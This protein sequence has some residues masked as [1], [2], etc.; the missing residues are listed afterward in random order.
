MTRENYWQAIDADTWRDAMTEAVGQ[1]DELGQWARLASMVH[2]DASP[3]RSYHAGV[4]SGQESPRGAAPAPDPF[5][6]VRHQTHSKR[7]NSGRTATR[8]T[9]AGKVYVIGP[10]PFRD[11]IE[12]VRVDGITLT[13]LADAWHAIYGG[14]H[15]CT[16]DDLT[17]T[18]PIY[19]RGKMVVRNGEPVTR[20]VALRACHCSPFPRLAG[21]DLR[22]Y[23]EVTPE[24]RDASYV[25]PT[26]T[27]RTGIAGGLLSDSEHV[28]RTIRGRRA[29]GT[30]YAVTEHGRY[31]DAI[32]DRSV[33]TIDTAS[34]PT[35]VRLS[36][37]PRKSDPTEST[38][39]GVTE[40][41][42]PASDR[43]HLWHGHRLI[44]RASAVRSGSDTRARRNAR[45]RAAAPWTPFVPAVRA[46]I[47][48]TDPF[49]LNGVM[50]TLTLPGATGRFR[51]RLTY[52]DGTTESIQART[53]DRVARA[54]Y[55]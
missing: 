20:T 30:R 40:L 4:K 7:S 37:R 17:E 9:R 27:H 1:Y 6:G 55:R 34:H 38:R 14:E 10:D 12:L 8:V 45:A 39:D 21:T 28:S 50:V 33:P 53:P 35:R 52:C 31:G 15:E 19:R 13:A 22:A 29:D 48:T 18:R 54:I 44:P 23:A 32:T 51:A 43:E 49:T 5:E 41:V 46:A 36:M 47:G 11:D 42:A 26:A 2:G 24:V 3:E 16:C 25:T